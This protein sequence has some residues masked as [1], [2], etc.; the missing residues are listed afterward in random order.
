MFKIQADN[1]F[2]FFIFMHGMEFMELVLTVLKS[3]RVM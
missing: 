2:D 3:D 1:H